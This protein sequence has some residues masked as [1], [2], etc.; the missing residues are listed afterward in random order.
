MRWATYGSWEAV[1]IILKLVVPM[2]IA[3]ICVLL[4]VW[5][6]A[7][8]KTARAALF[9]TS[10]VTSNTASGRVRKISS[11]SNAGGTS[12]NTKVMILLCVVYFLI[13]LPNVFE[14]V[15]ISMASISCTMTFVALLANDL[16]PAICNFTLFTRIFDGLIIFV[17]PEFRIAFFNILHCKFCTKGL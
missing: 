8:A 11:M 2:P 5:R 4:A 6:I 16:F 10:N 13:C 15:L 17:V 1:T 12:N 9:H 3:A 14:Y 7:T